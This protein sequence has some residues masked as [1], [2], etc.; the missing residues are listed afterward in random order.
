MGSNKKEFLVLPVDI[1][2]YESRSFWMP[3]EIHP[4]LENAASP[5][6]QL[7]LEADDISGNTLATF[8]GRI[9]LRRY[10]VP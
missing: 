10:T 9:E 3:L 2:A 1:P 6:A 5:Q 4:K 7:Y 8:D